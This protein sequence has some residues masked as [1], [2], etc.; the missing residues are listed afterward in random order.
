MRKTALL[1][2]G[3]SIFANMLVTS[4]YA[5]IDCYYPTAPGPDDWGVFI[6]E[7]GPSEANPTEPQG[8]FGQIAWR[9]N[10]QVSITCDVNYQVTVKDTATNGKTFTMVIDARAKPYIDINGNAVY[11]ALASGDG[12]KPNNFFC[13]VSIDHKADPL[14]YK[15][16][17]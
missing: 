12:L 3:L 5:R 7:R 14:K 16:C 15:F 4:A 13:F 9:Q 8:Y 1:I 11:P 17:N 6:E 10:V 2:L